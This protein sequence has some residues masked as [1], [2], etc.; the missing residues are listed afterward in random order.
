MIIITNNTFNLSRIRDSVHYYFFFAFVSFTFCTINECKKTKMLHNFLNS[1][2]F[3]EMCLEVKLFITTKKAMLR[4]YIQSL[5]PRNINWFDWLVDLIDLIDVFSYIFAIT[6]KAYRAGAQ[7]IVLRWERIYLSN[8]IITGI[9]AMMFNMRMM[10]MTNLLYNGIETMMF[11]GCIINNTFGAVWFDKR[12][13]SFYLITMSRFP[14]FLIVASVRI[15]YSIAEFV[16]GR[17]LQKQIGRKTNKRLIKFGIF[18][19]SGM[20][21]IPLTA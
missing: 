2:N 21:S 17:S 1:L 11:I 5:L 16:V 13:W 12:I 6:Q 10:G 8:L 19:A 7:T 3:Y 9:M 14:G 18:E 4:K 15:L 20:R